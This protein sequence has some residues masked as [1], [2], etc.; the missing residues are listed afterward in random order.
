M[1]PRSLVTLALLPI[2]AACGH[3][4]RTGAA[5]ETTA[6]PAARLDAAREAHAEPPPADPRAALEGEARALW[7]WFTEG[8]RGRGFSDDDLA[9][10][11]DAFRAPLSS[12][13]AQLAEGIPPERWDRVTEV[14]H[15]GDLTHFLVDL[16]EEDPNL[17]C[18]TLRGAP[19]DPRVVHL[20][21]IFI[22]LDR[23]PAPPTS[24]F[25]DV[26]DDRRRWMRE[27]ERVTRDVRVFS[28]L[29]E[30]RGRDEALAWFRDGAG[31]LL[32][33]RT[34]VPFV[35]PGRAWV[36]YTCWEQAHLRGNEV[37]LRALREDAA[38]IHVV[39]RR[40]AAYERTGHLRQQIEA[41]DFRALYES[42]W[43]DR[44]RAAGWEIDFEYDEGGAVTFELSR[45]DAEE[46]RPG[47]AL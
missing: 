31:Y 47:E 16:G 25:P 28:L 13:L 43:V 32:S 18:I 39:S 14:H 33:A 22:R 37:T 4:P 11:Y 40:L 30:E 8:V 41:D 17:F 20:E 46:D 36:L 6:A 19:G 35:P 12:F 1:G 44:A 5:S 2:A 21:N 29:V 45:T 27:E 9:P 3:C 10:Y 24:D 38:T 23:T 42:V 26:D 15:V 7:A 34:W